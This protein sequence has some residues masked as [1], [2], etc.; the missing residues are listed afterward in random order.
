M[1]T[2]RRLRRTRFVIGLAGPVLAL[3]LTNKTHAQDFGGAPPKKLTADLRAN[4]IP[5]Q[6]PVESAASQ[7]VV[8]DVQITGN[9]HK[10]SE[11][12]KS[13]I[14]TYP[15]KPY[16]AEMVKDDVKRLFAT[17]WFRDVRADERDTPNGIVVTFRVIERPVIHEVKFIGN[18]VFN[19]DKLIEFT[20]LKPGNSMDPG[21]NLAMARRVES[22][23]HEKGYPYVSVELLE[24]G[25]SG[26]AR[27]VMKINEGP[28][29]KINQ[30]RFVGNSFV[31]ANR[32]HYKTSAWAR[33]F[34]WGGR[35]GF[36]GKY[37]P[38]KVEE[39]VAALTEYYRG[40][41]FLDCKIEP[42]TLFTDSKD[43]VVL[44]YEITEGPR[45]KV[46]DVIFEGNKIKDKTLLSKNLKMVQGATIDQ[47]A[48]KRDIQ[49]VK[50]SYGKEGYKNTVVN[51]DLRFAE[52][53]GVVEVVYKVME[54]TP[55]RVGEI[56][57]VGNEVTKSRVVRSYLTLTPGDVADTT[58]MRE[59]QQK[60][61]ET[62]LFNIDPANNVM[63]TVEWD[64]NNDPESYFQDILVRVQEAQTGSLLLGVGV[65]SDAGINGSFIINERNFDLFRVPTSFG[66]L[67]SGRAFR[68]AGQEFRLE[69]VPGDL[70]NRYAV[71]IRE[72]KLFGSDYSLT[73]TGYYFNRI[74]NEY[75]EERV[76]AR[77]GLGRQFTREI[78]G[79]ITYRIEGVN[80]S[81]PIVPTPPDL[82]AALNY[83]F[84]T[85]VRASLNHDTRD[86][87]LDPGKG[88]YLEAGYEQVFGDF[89]Y[90]VLTLE[91]RQYF[92]LYSR[93]DGS[94][95]HTL[96]A[97]GEVGWSG[98]DTPM[99]E[100]F[101]AGGFRTIR[102]FDFRGVS[103]TQ[104]NVHVGGNFMMLTGLEYQFPLTADD[105]LGWVFFCDAGTVESKLEINDYRAS[106]G[107]GVR[108]K[109]PQMG[110]VPLAFDFGF[111]VAKTATD[112][113][114]VFSFF[115]G[116]FR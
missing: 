98:S 72:P 46:R 54:D 55:K 58:K 106:V 102:G 103:P 38:E 89:T 101:Y 104:S 48:F 75:H 53:K 15:G 65:N 42:K 25:Q 71:T 99:F 63:P 92:T 36:G 13:R 51:A 87:A 79:S 107:F 1:N 31:S 11:H 109:I 85:S 26:D 62:R 2:A 60:L 33:N 108:I 76:G 64:P 74:Y 73:T 18:K 67:F 115:L 113:K 90:P 14:K 5:D 69:A 45:Y 95:K 34:G 20:A 88:H 12:I 44:T 59:S 70:V 111:P 83:S 24:G 49:L 29:T 9:E 61:T 105:N 97:R 10:I 28:K 19:N 57:V 96:T 7:K 114:Q 47:L 35:W 40:N 37:D 22:K 8:A 6:I 23:Y 66:D 91:G 4:G 80:I 16:S 94:G 86:S 78:G 39:D 116:I 77:F 27:V 82:E 100:R 50:D 56:K 81:N 112:D 93:G 30:V 21:Q 68:G 41:G 84:L 52:E 32:L 17:S 110:P 43:G 3:S